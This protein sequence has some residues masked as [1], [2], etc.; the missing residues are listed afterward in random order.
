VYDEIN[1]AFHGSHPL[2]AAHKW[3]TT[4]SGE[5]TLPGPG[6]HFIFS[7]HRRIG[8]IQ[9]WPSFLSFPLRQKETTTP[10][11]ARHLR[12]EIHQSDSALLFRFVT[13]FVRCDQQRERLST[14]AT[15][16]PF[17]RIN[18]SNCT[19]SIF[20]PRLGGFVSVVLNELCRVAGLLASDDDH[21]HTAL[22]QAA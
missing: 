10:D 21:V 6:F 11:I 8:P 15:V 9:D 16:R 5:A 12:M 13:L 18:I 19:P 3:R 17:D 14:C 2:C 4:G 22:A 1:S 20:R 7:F